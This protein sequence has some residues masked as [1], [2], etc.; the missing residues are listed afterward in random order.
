MVFL[1]CIISMILDN[2]AQVRGWSYELT[3]FLSAIVCHSV[4]PSFSVMIFGLVSK[5]LNFSIFLH[6]FRGHR[7]LTFESDSF[8]AKILNTDFR[9]LSVQN[10]S[11]FFLSA[12]SPNQ[13]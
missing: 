1:T 13:A 12:F 6:E 11:F 7:G 9:G 4:F 5:R 3:P 10:D 8:S 2:Y